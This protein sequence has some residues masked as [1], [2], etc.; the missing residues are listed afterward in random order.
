[1]TSEIGIMNQRGIALAA[2]SAV[3]I[4]NAKVYNNAIKLFTLDSQHNIGIMIYGNANINGV[5]WEVVIKAYREEIKDEVEDHLEDYK[6]SFINFIQEKR[7]L[8]PEVNNFLV[9]YYVI[10][11]LNIL[12]SNF[13][14][15]IDLITKDSSP[16][17]LLN[18]IVDEYS[19]FIPQ[20]GFAEKI[21]ESEFYA[22]NGT[23]IENY[24]NSRF[25]FT[26]DKELNEKIQKNIY[27]FLK[28]NNYLNDKTGVV[29]AGYGKKDY[30]PKINSFITDGL[31]SNILKFQEKVNAD[32]KEYAGLYPFAQKDMVDT[33]ING[34]DPRLEDYKDAE[35]EN[36]K[37]SIIDTVGSEDKEKIENIFESGQNDFNKYRQENITSPIINMTENLS[38]DELA[39]MAETFVSLTSFK[40]K[41]SGD[42]QTVGGPVDVLVISKSDG[43]IWIKR[44]E[45]FNKEINEGY[46]LRR[47]WLRK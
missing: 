25:N 1:M 18:Y 38:L 22:D 24:I 43:P 14:N 26:I 33:V 3:T 10:D 46:T 20:K 40:R 32:G 21:N 19:N 36:M 16:Q 28:S 5:P 11:Y 8:F 35:F 17:E 2:D 34:I 4:G 41:F 29:F 37:K 12:D 44:K 45:Y 42:M 13:K 23:S 31:Y 39:I 6:K 9:N 15:N 47:K 7:E 30:F 27:N